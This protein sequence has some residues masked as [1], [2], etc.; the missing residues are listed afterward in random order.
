MC[1]YEKKKIKAK[2]KIINKTL[3][4]KNKFISYQIETTKSTHAQQQNSFYDNN[5][6]FFLQLVFCVWWWYKV[7]Y[8]KSC[9]SIILSVIQTKHTKASSDIDT[10]IQKTYCIRHD[11]QN[12]TF[13]S[14]TH[15]HF[16]KERELL[17]ILWLYHHRIIIINSTH[18]RVKCNCSLKQ[19]FLNKHKRSLM[20]LFMWEQHNFGVVKILK[21]P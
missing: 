6:R 16:K 2:K 1:Y 12:R 18:K 3:K 13:W 14:H 21:R 17:T 8:E 19:C 20:W 7:V 9:H 5:T 11:N 15:K 4:E 10:K